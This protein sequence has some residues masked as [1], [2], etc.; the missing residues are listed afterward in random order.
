MREEGREGERL[1]N[2]ERQRPGDLPSFLF[3]KLSLL[4][5]FF[6]LPTSIFFSLF[7]FLKLFISLREGNSASTC[8]ALTRNLLVRIMPFLIIVFIFIKFS[9]LEISFGKCEWL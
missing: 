7:F 6:L 2:T 1:R 5:P 9:S 8:Q 4:S 3:S